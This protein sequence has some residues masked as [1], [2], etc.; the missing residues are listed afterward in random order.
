MYILL[1]CALLLLLLFQ[2]AKYPRVNGPPVLAL[3]KPDRK[4]A[5]KKA[6]KRPVKIELIKVLKQHK[7]PLLRR[8][9]DVRRVTPYGRRLI[10]RPAAE[11]FNAVKCS[12]AAFPGY[13]M[14]G[15]HI[16]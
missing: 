3:S 16:L 5:R 8:G 2:L 10:W 14:P 4:T 1:A 12:S 9:F 11:R 7:K 6:R 15:V 13:P